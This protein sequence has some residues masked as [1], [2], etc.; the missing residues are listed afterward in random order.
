V[1]YRVGDCGDS[2]WTEW[3][4]EGGREE[5]VEIKEWKDLVGRVF[6]FRIGEG[7]IVWRPPKIG[8][9]ASEYFQLIE[10]VE[11]IEREIAGKR[12]DEAVFIGFYTALNHLPKLSYIH[13]EGTPQDFDVVSVEPYI[14]SDEKYEKERAKAKYVM[15]KSIKGKKPIRV[16]MWCCPEAEILIYPEKIF[17]LW[18]EAP[19]WMKGDSEAIW[20]YS[21]IISGI[22]SDL[23]RKRKFWDVVDYPVLFKEKKKNGRIEYR[24]SKEGVE[25]VRRIL[26]QYEGRKWK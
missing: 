12:A 15:E 9:V 14:I 7:D 21:L 1:G 23:K 17:W 25:L 16:G 19:Q 2:G 10:L 26:S 8:E 18:R 3:I 5:M 22:V 11:V 24:R 20:I 4:F 13:L 6:F